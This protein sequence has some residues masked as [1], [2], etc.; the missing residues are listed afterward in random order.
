MEGVSYIANCRP[1][2]RKWKCRINEQWCFFEQKVISFIYLHSHLST[3]L[4]WLSFLLVIHHL[5]I[6]DALTIFQSFISHLSTNTWFP[7]QYAISFLTSTN[8]NLSNNTLKPNWSYS[9]SSSFICFFFYYKPGISLYAQDNTK[10]TTYNHLSWTR[11][12]TWSYFLL[13]NW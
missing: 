12:R 1:E 13:L 5:F 11:K 2:Y 10:L 9:I 8:A 3:P 4:F 6:S 7:A